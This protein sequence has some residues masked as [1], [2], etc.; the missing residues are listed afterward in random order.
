MSVSEHTC[1]RFLILASFAIWVGQEPLKLLSTGSF[2][3]S[4]S[5]SSLSFFSHFIRASRRDQAASSTFPL[6]SPSAKYPTSWLTSSAF[7]P[8]EELSS[9][10]FSPHFTTWIAFS[11]GF[12]SMFLTRSTLNIHIS[13]K[14]LFKMIYVFS[15]MIE[16]FSSMPFT[17]FLSS[18]QNHL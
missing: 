5:F 15:K 1:I 11:P 16:A 13:Y 9:A 14:I 3:P 6:K 18:Q 17:F 7:Y 2:Y 10:K 4:S 12:K 8:M